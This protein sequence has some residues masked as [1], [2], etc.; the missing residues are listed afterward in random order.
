MGKSWDFDEHDEH[1]GPRFT[2][3]RLFERSQ[4]RISKEIYDFCMNRRAQIVGVSTSDATIFGILQP[5]KEKMVLLADG[6]ATSIF[7]PLA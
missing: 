5:A 7:R 6:A 3:D 2:V 1:W 4:F